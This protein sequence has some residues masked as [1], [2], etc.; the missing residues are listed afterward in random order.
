MLAVL[1]AIR[2]ERLVK[3]AEIQ[4]TLAAARVNAG[5]TQGEMAKK[6]KLSKNTIVSWEKGRI[7]PKPAQFEMYCRICDIS[8]D[9]V[10]LG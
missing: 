3:L 1:S 10:V 4:I 2:G 6:M 7:K 8:T 9:Y 5:L